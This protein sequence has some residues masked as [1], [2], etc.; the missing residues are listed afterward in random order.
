MKQLVIP[1]VDQLLL[2]VLLHVVAEDVR[3]AREERRLVG[4]GEHPERVLVHVE[5]VDLLHAALDELRVHVRERAEI[6]DAALAQVIQQRLHR[7]EILD[8]Q[9]HRRMLEQPARVEFALRRPA[10]DV[11]EFRDVLDRDEHAIPARLVPRQDHGFQQ[12]V[13]APAVERVVHRL[14]DELRLAGPQLLQFIDVRLQHVVAKHAGE[15]LH[16]MIDILRAEERQRAPVHLDHANPRRTRDDARRVRGQM[17]A[18][19]GDARRPPAFEE[20]AHGAEILQPQRDGREVEHVGVVA[21]RALG[22]DGSDG[23]SGGLPHVVVHGHPLGSRRRRICLIIL[24]R[25]FFGTRGAVRRA[26]G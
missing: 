12:H 10:P 23:W 2:E 8:P 7:A 4:R 19:V 14:A 11:F 5:D 21:G 13:E 9:R 18:Q 17:R 26:K 3:E 24:T 16:E 25:H 20:L 22:C 6:D 1:E 15:V